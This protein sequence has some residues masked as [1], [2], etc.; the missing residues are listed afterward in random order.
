MNMKELLAGQLPPPD[1]AAQPDPDPIP[2]IVPEPPEELD[3]NVLLAQWTN[4]RIRQVLSQVESLGGVIS[5]A[6]ESATMPADVK[7]FV[8]IRLTEINAR[9]LKNIEAS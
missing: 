4:D 2:E 8:Y 5:A 6:F 3:V 1:P 7:R 9:L